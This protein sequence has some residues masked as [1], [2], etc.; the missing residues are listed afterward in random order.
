MYVCV[1]VCAR[2]IVLYTVAQRLPLALR[3]RGPRFYFRFVF[4][5]TFHSREEKNGGRGVMDFHYYALVPNIIILYT[6]RGSHIHCGTSVIIRRRRRRRRHTHLSK[7]K[8]ALCRR[9]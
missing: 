3:G 5:S 7:K 8:I 6:R 9:T 4:F 1:C 2:N